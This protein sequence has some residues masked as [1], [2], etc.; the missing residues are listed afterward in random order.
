MSNFA[1]VQAGILQLYARCT[2][3]IW[4][5]DAELFG[6]CFAEQGIWKIATMQMNGRADVTATFARLLAAC[7]KVQLITGIPV[8]DQDENG[9][10]FGRIQCT[11]IARMDD[12]SGAITLGVYF[13]RYVEEQG[14]WCFALRHFGMHYRGPMELPAELSGCPDY[15]PP[16]GFPAA[17]EPTYTKR[18]AS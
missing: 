16:P 5:K 13:D 12:G 15:G 18:F 4:R 14:R 17:D 2:D 7:A 10:W 9:Q 6:H 3:A 8:L 11:E 1:D